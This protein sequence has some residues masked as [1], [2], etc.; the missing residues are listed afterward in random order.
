VRVL[1]TGGT[2]F[3]GAEIAR[4]LVARGD[5]VTLFSRSG[6]TDRVADIADGLTIRRGDVGD[7]DHVL[8]AVKEAAPEV[9]YHLGAML[10]V[11]S[12]AD[13]SGSIQANVLGTFYVF[14]AAR[15]FDVPKV[16]FASSMAVFGSGVHDG[17]MRDDSIQK[18]TLIYGAT[19]LFGENLASFYRRKYGLDVRGFRYPSVVGPG[20]S[21]PG[22]V[23][24]TSWMIEE[25]AKGNPFVV[26]VKPETRCPLL[27]YKDAARGTI[28]LADAPADRIETVHYLMDGV[29]PTPS[30]GEI[31][32]AVRA[33]IPTARI[34]F[35]PNLETQALLDK[36]LLPIDDSAA[37]REWDW[38]PRFDLDAMVDDFLREMRD[39]AS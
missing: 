24:Y 31:A 22:V 1:I 15:L 37:E 21:N 26:W 5:E 6:A 10:S 27:Y 2:G 11:P 9:I 18:P 25:S 16:L 4:M 38:Q 14:E 20:V 8:H 39:R 35:E 13:P 28:E 7:F 30:A 32:D 23:Q 33:R 19:K 36:A 3:V 29:P 34:S 17:V 12:E